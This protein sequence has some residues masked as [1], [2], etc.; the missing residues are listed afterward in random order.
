VEGGGDSGLGFGGGI[1][2][3]VNGNKIPIPNTENLT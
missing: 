2:I 3:W 1:A